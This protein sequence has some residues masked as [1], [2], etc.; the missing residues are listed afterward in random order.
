MEEALAG[1]LEDYGVGDPGI[2][3]RV[4]P[5]ESEG[6][7]GGSFVVHTRH[8]GRWLRH[9]IPAALVHGYLADEEAAVDEFKRWV[10]GWIRSWAD[11]RDGGG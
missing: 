6:E 5:P 1:A 7:P 9:E 8:G 2:E 4:Q 10:D 11:P 3:L